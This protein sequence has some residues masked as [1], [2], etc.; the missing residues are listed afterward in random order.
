MEMESYISLVGT[1]YILSAWKC[2]SEE[3]YS[4]L[5]KRHKTK[6]EYT[7]G[8]PD[9]CAIN[10][11]SSIFMEHKTGDQSNIPN[12]YNFTIYC[13]FWNAKMIYILSLM[14]FRSPASEPDVIPLCHS[15]SMKYFIVLFWLKKFLIRH[16]GFC[17]N[18]QRDVKQV[19]NGH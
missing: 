2:L 14:G 19:G 9:R 18:T 6:P 3:I 16:S 1:I 17:A 11:I 10:Y 15:D 5:W 4:I 13:I 12:I 7:N 8:D